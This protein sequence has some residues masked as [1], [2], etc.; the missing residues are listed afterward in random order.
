LKYLKITIYEIYAFVIIAF[1]A[2]LR[3]LLAAL[4]WPPTNSDEG[5]MGIMALHIAY[6]GEHP[7]FFYGYNYMGS[8]ELH[9]CAFFIYLLGPSLFALRLAVI[10]LATLFFISIYLLT[11]VLYSKK[12]ALVTLA[13][14]SLGSTWVFTR[15]IIVTGG[16]SETLLFGSLAFLLATWLSLTYR[17]GS[18]LRTKLWRLA[19]FGCWGLVIG[20]GLW[21][22]L[23]VLPFFAMAAL[24]LV[25]FCWRELLAWAWPLVLLGL[26]LGAFPSIHHNIIQAS[27]AQSSF[28]TILGQL[29]GNSSTGEAPRTLS[30]TIDGVKSTLL[31]SV[32]M[33][34]GNPVCPVSELSF[35]ADNTPPSTQCT[36]IHVGW[37]LGYLTLLVTAFLLNARKL[38]KLRT[39][40]PT[41]MEPFERRQAVVRHMAQLLM[42][43]AGGLAITVYS[44]SS[45]PIVWPGIHARYLVG[46]LIITPSVIAPLWSAASTLKSQMA[47]L[48]RARVVASRAILV[49]IGFVLLVGTFMTF[50]EVPAAQ[51]ANQRQ[52][53]LIN[54]LMRIGATHIYTGYWTCDSLAFQSD[55]RIICGVI[56][57]N[58]QPTHNRV[59]HY[60]TI[61]S[62]DPHAA[63]VFPVHDPIFPVLMQRFEQSGTPYRLFFFDGYEVFQPE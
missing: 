54:N 2:G 27:H 15:E 50:S 19:G 4:N 47:R 31:I 39:R 33:A 43:S 16:S 3:I 6:R 58:L 1:A 35:W 14:L 41:E 44:L 38:W 26:I 52:S 9:L 17:R 24:L 20:L 42:L 12:L 18:S 56:V 25:L 28:S 55:E 23:V 37:G 59:P 63:Y 32:P 10:L 22:D 40:T 11:S 21:N 36:L 13:L 34:T 8:L 45:A 30:E 57:L 53:D 7:V 48:E 29:H 60:Y 62:T 46:L 49:F 61:V 5:T 51:A